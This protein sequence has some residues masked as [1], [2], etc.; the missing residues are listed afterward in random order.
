MCEIYR[1]NF[2]SKDG[3]NMPVIF[4]QF[5]FLFNLDCKVA[6]LN[7]FTKAEKVWNILKTEHLWYIG[8]DEWCWMGQESN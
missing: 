7:I 1:G 5:P 2:L 4:C 3:V 6:V 8:I